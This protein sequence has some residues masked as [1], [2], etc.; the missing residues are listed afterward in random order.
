MSDEHG[1]VDFDAITATQKETWATG[2][3]H[4]IARQ[5]VCM[6]EALCEAVVPM[7]AN[8]SRMLP[9]AV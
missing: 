3:F 1:T 4:Q 2:D 5:N 6:A 8:G 9:A 7:L